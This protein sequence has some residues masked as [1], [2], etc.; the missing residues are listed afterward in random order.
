MAPQRRGSLLRNCV[1]LGAAAT[2]RWAVPVVAE[3]SPAELDE[4]SAR[5]ELQR[6]ATD[7]WLTSDENGGT[8]TVDLLS[9]A[10]CVDDKFGLLQY[11]GL[12]CSSQTLH[13]TEEACEDAGFQ[14]MDDH[15]NSLLHYCRDSTLTDIVRQKGCGFQ[16][17]LSY[18]LADLCPF[19]CYGCEEHVP[20]DALNRLFLD[21]T[22]NVPNIQIADIGDRQDNGDWVISVELNELTFYDFSLGNLAATTVGPERRYAI[23][24]T[25]HA[26]P[27]LT[28]ELDVVTMTISASN[29]IITGQLDVLWCVFTGDTSAVADISCSTG[30]PF[31]SA[32]DPV[33]VEINTAQGLLDM[34]FL[35]GSPDLTIEPPCLPAGAGY[36]ADRSDSALACTGQWGSMQPQTMKDAPLGDLR[37]AFAPG[38]FYEGVEF[39]QMTLGTLYEIYANGDGFTSGLINFI[40]GIGWPWDWGNGDFLQE[41]LL[42]PDC[43]V[44]G[45][46]TDYLC[47]KVAKAMNDELGGL[48]KDLS[49]VVEPY[50]NPESADYLCTTTLEATLEAECREENKFR[51]PEG[52]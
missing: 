18:S 42:C 17:S 20:F 24:G 48:L 52:M 41:Y 19:T 28:Q 26:G 29:F 5:R 16:W 1:L 8:G 14:W 43:Y 46:L 7:V 34:Q 21:M 45:L 40:Q 12:A 3:R 44:I 6:T 33:T 30:D 50:L 23:N 9:H 38:G 15:D 39:C 22:I 31:A 2:A 27:G 49:A 4:S 10:E 47:S 11:Y 51:G 36:P 13:M 32:E 25:G 37:P 35:L